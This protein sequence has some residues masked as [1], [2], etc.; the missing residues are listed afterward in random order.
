MLWLSSLHPASFH[1]EASSDLD[2]L[3]MLLNALPDEPLMR[4]LE[5]ERKGRRDDYPIRP[6]W[7][8]LSAG[9]VYQHQSIE[10]PRRDLLRNAQLRQLC[11]FDV[12]GGEQRSLPNGSIPGFCANYS[13]ISGR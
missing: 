9:I 3:C 10:N 11:G 2:R 5:A 6:L 4:A 1:V 7:N 12:F 8:S 13:P